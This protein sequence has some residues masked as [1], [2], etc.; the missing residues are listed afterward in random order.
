MAEYSREQRNQLSRAIANS[1]T[2]SRQLKGFVDNRLVNMATHIPQRKASGHPIMQYFKVNGGTTSAITGP[3]GETATICTQNSVTLDT[4]DSLISDNGTATGTAA[5]KDWL[6][7]AHLFSNGVHAATQC[8]VINQNFGGLGGSADGNIHPG[9]QTLNQNHKNGMEEVVKNRHADMKQNRTGNSLTY[10]CSFTGFPTVPLTHGQ[11]IP[12]PTI[13]GTLVENG[14]QLAPAMPIIH[15]VPLG[16][17][18][19][20]P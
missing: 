8:H 19:C 16:D 4:N 14:P 17:G 10:T 3:A 12:D 5:W 20:V 2:G 13:S 18:M 11:F 15:D 1:E 9:S 6:K 7:D